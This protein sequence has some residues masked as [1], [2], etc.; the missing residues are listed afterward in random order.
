MEVSI[1]NM[2]ELQS[3]SDTTLTTAPRTPT[4]PTNLGGLPKTSPHRAQQGTVTTTTDRGQE[5][6][7]PL[8]TI[9]ETDP[10]PSSNS[11]E[12]WGRVFKKNEG[13]GMESRAVEDLRVT[14]RSE[15]SSLDSP[16]KPRVSITSSNVMPQGSTS[17]SPHTN[18][19]SPTR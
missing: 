8:E 11:R 6:N 7:Y 14:E 5:S 10:G 18:S 1:S 4:P 2:R 9:A 16:Y 3:H 15:N 12:G 17:D 19:R 13:G